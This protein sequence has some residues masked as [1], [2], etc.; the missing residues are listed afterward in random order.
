MK[1]AVR[2]VGAYVAALSI[3]TRFAIGAIVCAVL[4][5][6]ASLAI[7]IHKPEAELSRLGM[8]KIDQ[9]MRALWSVGRAKGWPARI[10]DGKLRFGEHTVNDNHAIVDE[11]KAIGAGTVTI[12]QRQGDE[13]VRVTTNVPGA[14]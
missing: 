6:A 9:D 1:K 5:C 8:E 3:G 7:T 14:N 12:F 13:F 2:A 11:V 4:A 10:E